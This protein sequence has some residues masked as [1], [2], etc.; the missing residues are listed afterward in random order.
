MKVKTITK[1]PVV[2]S[3]IETTWGLI[4]NN[5]SF[6]ELILSYELSKPT[7]LKV[8]NARGLSV[9][10]NEEEFAKALVIIDPRGYEQVSE[11]SKVPTFYACRGLSTSS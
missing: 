5:G 4:S 6:A 9:H 7:A 2:L 1:M 11:P 3:G 8:N 10:Y